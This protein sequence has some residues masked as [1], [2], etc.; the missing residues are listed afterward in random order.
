MKEVVSV[1]A[2]SEYDEHD[3]SSFFQAFTLGNRYCFARLHFLWLEALRVIQ[4]DT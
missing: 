3:F 4:A 1:A 2:E